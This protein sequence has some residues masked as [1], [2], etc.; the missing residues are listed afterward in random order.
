WLEALDRRVRGRLGHENLG[1][2]APDHHEAIETMLR[3]ESPNVRRDLLGEVPLVFPPLDVRSVEPFDVSLVKDRG[4]RTDFL[5]FRPH[6]LEQRGLD[7]AGGARRGVAVVRKNVPSP[8]HEI[9][10]RRQRDDLGNLGRASLCPL[11]ETDRAHLGQRSDRLGEPF[12]NCEHAGNRRS[13]DGTQT[14]EQYAQ[15]AVGWSDFDGGRHERE[16]YQIAL[17]LT[18]A[19]AH[20]IEIVNDKAVSLK[21][22]RDCLC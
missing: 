1:A 14:N 20:S 7:D 3:L 15:A 19:L 6:L 11:A 13:T 22:K 2:A 21:V 8:K 5:E 17:V 10:R 12:S 18:V 4:P 16:L 9:V